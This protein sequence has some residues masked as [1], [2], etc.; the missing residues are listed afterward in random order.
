MHF[1]KFTPLPPLESPI[2]V[3][4]F[5]TILLMLPNCIP[6]GLLQR[7]TQLSGRVNFKMLPLKLTKL[8]ELRIFRSSLFHSFKAKGKK[9]FL[10]GLQISNLQFVTN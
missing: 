5:E 2:D 3:K 10:F 6:S 1:E 7:K 8:S 9:R 4:K